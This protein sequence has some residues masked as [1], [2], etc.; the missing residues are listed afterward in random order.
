M[1]ATTTPRFFEETPVEVVRTLHCSCGT[2]FDARVRNTVESEA[3]STACP[4]CRRVVRFSV[5][6]LP[7]SF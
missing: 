7:L 1:I 3:I 4:A 6:G 2:P 5:A